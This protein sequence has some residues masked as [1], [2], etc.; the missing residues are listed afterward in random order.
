MVNGQNWRHP[1]SCPDAKVAD[2]HF[3]FPG[4]AELIRNV[5]YASIGFVAQGEE[6]RDGI[7]FI[8]RARLTGFRFADYFF[9]VRGFTQTQQR[10]RRVR[11]AGSR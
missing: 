2:F 11:A 3:I 4:S 1:A 5:H 6:Y 8:L 9:S 10:A 7:R